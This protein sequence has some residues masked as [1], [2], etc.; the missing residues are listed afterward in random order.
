MEMKSK[1]QGIIIIVCVFVLITGVACLM[2][3]NRKPLPVPAKASKEEIR[4]FIASR[5]FIRMPSEKRHAFMKDA[6]KYGFDPM[7]IEYKDPAKRENFMRNMEF[8]KQE[9]LKM[10]FSMP[11]AAQER[12]L[13]EAAREMKQRG[14]NNKQSAQS[15]P[16]GS[17]T[18]SHR[19]ALEGQSPEDRARSVEFSRRLKKYMAQ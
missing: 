3:L 15:P 19:K 6:R 12:A 4:E 18:L 9:R 7:E 11:P 2:I 14:K 17:S 5:D 16:G 1:K 13:Q 8:F 10:F